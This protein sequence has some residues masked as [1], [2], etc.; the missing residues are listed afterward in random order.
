[1]QGVLWKRRDVFKNKWRPR[2]FVL[3][4]EQSI[5]TYYLFSNESYVQQ[6]HQAESGNR[7]RQRTFS[8]SSN[9]SNNTMDYDVV[10]RGTI[11]LLGCTAEANDVLTRSE[12][13][14]YALTITNH[15]TATHCH[16]AART[17]TARQRWIDQIQ[18]A[19][20]SLTSRESS[21]ERSSLSALM[22]SSA[23]TAQEQTSQQALDGA[24]GEPASSS[25]TPRNTWKTV[26][27]SKLT[28]DV[29]SDITAKI[30][31][32]LET[33][34]P[35]TE[36]EHHPDWKFRYDTD[37]LHC[38]VH[39]EKPM[40]R[41]IR[42]TTHH[43][44]VDYLQL[45]WDL[46]R[47]LDF[48]TNVR[49]QEGLKTYNPH[50]CLVHSIYH[51]VWPTSPRDFAST[52]H[53]RLVEQ[54]TTGEK[55][56]CLV[57]FS[58]RE[59]SEIKPA[60]PDHVRGTLHVSF[61]F[62]RPLAEGGCSHTRI[63][64]YDLN[65][66]I[67]KQLTQTILQ[68]QATL[69]KVMALYLQTIKPAAVTSTFDMDYDSIYK[70]L[71][72]PSPTP[73]PPTANQRELWH[74]DDS[75]VMSP[76][77][78]TV[79][80]PP[81]PSVWVEILV[82]LSPILF[83]RWMSSVSFRYDFVVFGIA[84]FLAIRWVVLQHRLQHSRLLPAHQLGQLSAKSTST[85]CCRFTVHL[86]DALRF[87]SNEQEAKQELGQDA[88]AVGAEL[89]VTHILIRALVRAMEK[90]PAL[91]ARSF[92]C[93]P[94]VYSMDMVWHN[95]NNKTSQWIPPTK[96]HSVQ[97]IADYLEA[98]PKAPSFWQTSVL[99]PSCRLWTP[100]DD[101]DP[102]QGGGVVDLVEWS[103]MDCPITV[104]VSSLREE[105]QDPTQTTTDLSICVTLQ[106][107]N[108]EACQSFAEH[109]QQLI[110]SPELCDD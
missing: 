92:P 41:S 78:P 14:L 61:N 40:I 11:Y 72:Q 12:E 98:T 73:S 82:L 6:P 60:A 43:H 39:K 97:A 24:G 15:E 27:S 19:T 21:V 84:S 95:T 5:L 83:L 26:P 102:C 9:V 50:T 52:A 100:C 59:A 4:P 81:P 42:S 25:A 32:L 90:Q 44:P 76:T 8:E 64:S 37:G 13:Q 68:Q 71:G 18:Q 101:S 86:K 46:P 3:H 1:M 58:C 93:F 74:E 51:A 108:S 35:Y 10:P 17:P 104:V 36:D 28:Q 79:P 48:Q 105:H 65:G 30:D 20:A 70:A 67:P 62:W 96:Q 66:Q 54:E 94:T 45:L 91:I 109:V 87:L 55:A 63:I 7:N 106:S 49:S 31:Q 69:P 57:A 34:L 56:L 103:G 80:P 22:N 88:A 2:W 33:H 47:I 77:I 99:G 23:V 89:G 75:I 38:S 107:S 110:Q 16:L 85:T 53:W 29:P